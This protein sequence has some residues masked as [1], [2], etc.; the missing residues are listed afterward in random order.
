VTRLDDG[1]SGPADGHVRTTTAAVGGSTRVVLEHVGFDDPRAA[2]LR[3]VMD[4]EME[5]RY[6]PSRAPELE[7]EIH[8]VLRID[9]ATILATVLAV[10]RHGVAVAHAALR[11]LGDDLEVKRVIVGAEYRGAGL[12]RL[13][14]NELERIARAAGAPRLILQTGDR[15]PEAVA[16]YERLG[17]T[18]IPVYEPYAAVMPFSLCFEKTLA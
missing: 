13:V 14:M 16:L 4:V 1:R 5:V 6:S 18:P 2:A 7:A 10:D 8:R 3:A 15:Q 12:G 17:Y 9:P 11:R